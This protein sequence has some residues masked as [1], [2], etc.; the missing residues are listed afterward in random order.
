[1]AHLAFEAAR[2]RRAPRRRAA[3]EGPAQAAW[4]PV[5][6]L[7]SRGRAGA[8]MHLQLQL[9]ARERVPRRGPARCDLQPEA[10]AEEG[11]VGAE[12]RLRSAPLN[13]EVELARISRAQL[14]QYMGG[15][16]SSD[17]T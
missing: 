13:L 11:L 7:P 12:W 3:A 17:S 14:L 9:H 4:G 5:E 8:R 6:K 10:Q 1:M 2:T 15:V 16:S